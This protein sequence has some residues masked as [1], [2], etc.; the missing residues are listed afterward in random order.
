MDC[1]WD[2]SSLV[3]F[4]TAFYAPR[5]L[6]EKRAVQKITFCRRC[7]ALSIS[8]YPPKSIAEASPLASG[9]PHTPAIVRIRLIR[10]FVPVNV[11]AKD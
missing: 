9:S 2:D 7:V 3:P 1:I 4:W 10:D 6:L 11:A 5:P 8:F